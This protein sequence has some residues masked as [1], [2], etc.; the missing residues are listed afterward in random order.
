MCREVDTTNVGRDSDP[1]GARSEVPR[2]AAH[3]RFDGHH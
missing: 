3:I 1:M 2:L